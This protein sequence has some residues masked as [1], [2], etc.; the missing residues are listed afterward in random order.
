MSSKT[1][2]KIGLIRLRLIGLA[3]L[4]GDYVELSDQRIE[5]SET[6]AGVALI[7]LDLAALL[8][9]ALEGDEPEG[10]DDE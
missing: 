4:T 6:A 7:F 2:E 8:D 10:G 9:D 3:A 5:Q 1:D